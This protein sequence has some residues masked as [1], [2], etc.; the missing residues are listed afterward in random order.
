[1]TVK[2]RHRFRPEVAKQVPETFSRRVKRAVRTAPVKHRVI[3]ALIIA[4]I[5]AILEFVLKYEV[6]AKGVE[7]FGVVPFA[8]RMIK[9]LLGE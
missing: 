2:T 1:M 7:L 6:A 9:A 4:A 3:T 8:D 5:W